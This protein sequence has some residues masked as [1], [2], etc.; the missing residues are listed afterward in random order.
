VGDG[1]LRLRVD[2]D[3]PPW[4]ADLDGA[5][6]VS[7]IQT[8]SFAGPVGSD[9]G[10]HRFRPGLRVVEA[11]PALPLYKPRYG[12]IEVRMRAV[13]DP[14]VLVACWMIGVE[15][16]PEHSAEICIAEVFGRE[17]GASS[18]TVRCGVHPFGDPA[19][20]DDVASTVLAIDAREAHD[21]AAAW[22]PDQV[23]FYVDERLVRVVPQSPAYPMLVLI[24]VFTFGERTRPAVA[25]IEWF[26]GWRPIEGPAARPPAFPGGM[27]WPG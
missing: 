12:L 4:P 26:R 23:A 27:T 5:L 24:D 13:D 17:M 3:Q 10:Q 21:Y 2:P 7:S 9:V 18:A 8:G 19:I 15:D 6:R 25:G 14:G 11:Q 16:R 20:Q 22:T 1:G